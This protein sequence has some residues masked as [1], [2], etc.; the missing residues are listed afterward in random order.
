M[1]RNKL[2]TPVLVK[3][4]LLDEMNAKLDELKHLVST[5]E[6]KETYND[7]DTN[8]R[9]LTVAPSVQNAVDIFHDAWH[10]EIPVDGVKSG[11]HDHFLTD[12]RVPDC[13]KVVSVAGKKILELGP[14]EGFHSYQLEKH[15]AGQVISIEANKVSFMKCLIVK[16]I[17]D[18]KTEYRLGDF[19][20]YLKDCEDKY[21][22]VFAS[23]VLYNMIDPVQLIFDISKVAD[24]LFLWTF[25]YSNERTD[26]Q[27]MFENEEPVL[28]HSKYKV[29]KR[30]YEGRNAQGFCGGERPYSMWP[31]RE[32]VFDSLNDAGFNKIDII[33]EKTH[34]EAGNNILLV[35]RKV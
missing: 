15:G 16:N 28:I 13:D 22:I 1:M 14:Y 10:C 25:Y 18:M 27:Q 30:L 31:E 12:M 19:R 29:H 35:A 23:G 3:L 34:E 20:E 9:Y 8:D 24:T 5:P 33:E 17:F 4:G 7:F 11:L 26:L 2:L 32:T 21:D 6:A